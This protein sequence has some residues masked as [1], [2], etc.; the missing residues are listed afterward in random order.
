MEKTL[1]EFGICGGVDDAADAL[2]RGEVREDLERGGERVVAAVGE[3]R[4][5]AAVAREVRHQLHKEALDAARRD[6][7][8]VGVR[9]RRPFTHLRRAVGRAHAHA[10][11][12]LLLQHP[13]QLPV[14]LLQP[15]V[16]LKHRTQ[17]KNRFSFFLC[18]HVC[19]V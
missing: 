4:E 1:D 7:H 6:E 11:A 16:A 2:V 12:R 19:C 14:L 10:A 8:R 15:L 5:G 18:C 3:E 9:G 13:Q 17:N